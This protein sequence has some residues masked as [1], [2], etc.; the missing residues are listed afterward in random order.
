[1]TRLPLLAL[2]L[3]SATVASAA[4]APA[5]RAQQGT[6]TYEVTTTIEITLPPEMQQ[7]ADRIPRTQTQTRVLAFTEAATRP[8]EPTRDAAPDRPRRGERGGRPD[9]PG[10]GG[11]MMM[12]MGT[13]A[14]SVSYTDLDA[15]TRVLQTDFLGRTFLVT[16]DVPTYAWRLTG[17]QAEYLGYPCQKATTMRDSVAVEAWFA[18]GIPASVGPDEYGGLPGLILLVT[19]D[20]GRRTFVAQS[21]ALEPPAA[22]TAPTEGRRVTRAEYDQIVRE[23]TE[24]MGGSRGLGGAT[25]IQIN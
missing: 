7:Y 1:M 18:P 5:A 8:T 24:E 4:L 23:K 14:P 20:G 25:I 3:A 16:S 19:E 10:R 6:V 17:E 11:P 12:Q 21:V 22:F 2:L 9:R 15:G 13:R